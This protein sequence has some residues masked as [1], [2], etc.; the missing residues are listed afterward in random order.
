MRSPGSHEMKGQGEGERA[1][2]MGRS[3]TAKRGGAEASGRQLGYVG[4]FWQL[5]MLVVIFALSLAGLASNGWADLIAVTYVCELYADIGLFSYSLRCGD[6]FDRRGLVDCTAYDVPSRYCQMLNALRVLATA[7]TVLAGLALASKAAE[8]LGR[9]FF[10]AAPER[11]KRFHAVGSAATFLSG[12]V[13]LCAMILWAVLLEKLYARAQEHPFLPEIASHSVKSATMG[14]GAACFAVAAVAA[15]VVSRSL[16]RAGSRGG[17]R[18]TVRRTQGAPYQ[19][20][21]LHV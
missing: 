18:I 20:V 3:A 17:E 4:D 2:L 11:T 13:G 19:S 12:L 16:A 9:S 1:P 10:A 7:T 8:G 15:L 5:S 14:W 6:F 21:E